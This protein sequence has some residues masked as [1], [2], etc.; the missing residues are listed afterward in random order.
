[1]TNELQTTKD[2]YR[3][4]RGLNT[5]SNEISFPDGYSTDESNYELLLDGS[6]R[7][8]KGLAQESGGSA[9]ATGESLSDTT[10]YRSYVWR[11]VGGDPSKNVIIHQVGTKLFISNDAETISTTYYDDPLD[12]RT[13]KV[14]DTVVDVTV[15]RELCSFSRVRGDLLITHKYL[16]PMYL[17]YDSTADE[18]TL[19]KVKLAVRDFYGIDDGVGPQVTPSSIDDDH[20]Y[21]LRNRGWIE[22]DISTFQTNST[23][24]VYPSKVMIWHRGY[25]RQ[26][27]VNYSDLD[28]IQIFNTAKLEA[29]Q[30]GQSDAPQGGL[31]L[32]P[33]DT[34]Y[35][36]STTNEG[37]EI[38]I[39]SFSFTAG[40]PFVGGTARIVCAS[41]HGRSSTDYVTI[42]G[43]SFDTSITVI[44]TVHA[45]AS[46]DGYWQITVVN[47]TTFDIT[48]PANTGLPTVGSTYQ[49]GQLNG[50]VSLPK[51]DG[52]ALSVGPSACAYHAGRCFYTGVDDSEWA[53]TVFFSKIAL[54]PAAF[55]VCYQE[56]D[57]TNPEINQLSSTDG[58][59]III[60]NLGEV[61]DMV[62]LRDLL[63]IFTDQG[64][65]EIGPGS[66]GVFSAGSYSVRKITE[67]ECSSKAGIV[68]LGNRVIYTGPRGIHIISPNVYTSVLEETSLS[69]ELVQTLWNDLSTAR[70]E[71][72]KSVYDNSLNR[73]YFL[74]TADPVISGQYVNQFEQALVLDLKVGAF[75]RFDFNTSTSTTGIVNAYAIT[76]SD[77]T[78]DN[79]KIKWTTRSTNSLTTCDLDQSDYTDFDGASP[80]PYFVTGWDN[81]GDFQRRR[82]APV[83]TVFAKRTET[84]YTETGSGY[85]PVNESSNLL[86]AYWDWTDDSVSGKIGSQNETYR[87]VRGFVPSGTGDVDGYPVVVTRNKIRGR[88]RV[89]QLRFDGAAGKDSHILGFSINYKVSR[90]R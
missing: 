49:N 22:Q 32:D 76:E 15:G 62:S 38:Q 73:V 64:V 72:V 55:G 78:S 79:K 23:G 39:S 56:A 74:Y 51:S 45:T 75:Y 8:R 88:G 87:H 61:Q 28:G 59:T 86:T 77:S 16:H 40:N 26:T 50:N 44:A 21:N 25:R 67:S 19:T 82:Q 1:M 30:F 53:D 7:R 13:F 65:W 57:P 34:R 5:E 70:Q 60:P 9:L 3:I 18:Y 84:G 81:I 14:D 80:N 90:S 29:E 71:Q 37:D 2:Y 20:R 83:V 33:L 52:K 46:L 4:N 11:G 27:D 17:S 12:L 43:N 36:A 41:A 42:S 85:D 68:R 24:N 58:G 35:S 47:A 89:L 66:R 31:F 69:E 6:R 54:K 48:V 10:G 63:L